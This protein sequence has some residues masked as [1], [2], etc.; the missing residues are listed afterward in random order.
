MSAVPTLG[1][2]VPRKH[3]PVAAAFGRLAMRMLGW[4]F[5]GEFPDLPKLVMIVVPHS[6][7]WDVPIG[8]AAKFALR[9]DAH[10]IAKHSVF[11]WPLGAVLRA[12]GGIPVNRTDARDFVAESAEA[13][14]VSPSLV[15][16]ITPEGTRAKVERW[17]SG[18][19]RIA[20]AAGVPILLTT[21]DYSRREIGFG[22]LVH[23]GDDYAADLATLQER[24]RPDM[25]RR[26]K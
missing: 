3:G 22:P 18:F 17:K 10:F 25:A 8:L 21:F 26:P 19:H 20:R 14:R 23:P 12:L 5:R 2:S 1:P 7:N 13:L 9:L 24:V 16:I 4:R 11:W 6:S 15:L